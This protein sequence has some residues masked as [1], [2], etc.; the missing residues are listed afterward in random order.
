MVEG[1]NP[2][3]IKSCHFGNHHRTYSFERNLFLAGG[4]AGAPGSNRAFL[5]S[6]DENAWR[7]L[8]SMEAG[9][10]Y[11][12]C[13]LVQRTGAAGETVREVVVAGGEY[14]S[15]VEIFSVEEESW[16]RGISN[17]STW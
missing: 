4:T 1:L 5:Y 17:R 12:A 3:V 16:R 14:D 15:S 9:R 13:G 6:L 2:E 7:E 10:R 11:H 8:P